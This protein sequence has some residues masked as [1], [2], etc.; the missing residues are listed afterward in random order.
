MY[1]I[2]YFEVTLP[3][4]PP[5]RKCPCYRQIQT[6][7]VSKFKSICLQQF[8]SNC[9]GWKI[10]VNAD[11]CA[12]LPTCCNF[13]NAAHTWIA[14]VEALAFRY[15]YRVYFRCNCVYLICSEWRFERSLVELGRFLQGFFIYFFYVG[16]SSCT[17]KAQTMCI[18]SC[19]RQWTEEWSNPLHVSLSL[20]LSVCP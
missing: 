7:P 12:S 2:Q 17:G 11:I 13:E 3:A 14:N 1:L 8:S 19:V 15:L 4:L 18:G 6:I 20:W 10:T 5:W 16:L 9:H